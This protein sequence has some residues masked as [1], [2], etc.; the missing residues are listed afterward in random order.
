MQ[1]Q[2]YTLGS[3]G[4]H[5]YILINEKTDEA[6]LVDPADRPEVL[7]EK[8]TGQG[9]TLRG[10]LLTHGHGDHIMAV[11]GLREKY[12]APVLAHEAEAP[13][14]SD[15]GLNLSRSLFG[16]PLSLK[17]DRLLKDGELVKLAGLSLKVLFT[18]GHTP[19]GCCY[20]AEEEHVLL[21]GDTLFCASIGRTDFP[22]G[23]M[24]TL[25]AS[26]REKL[27]PLPDDTKVYPGHAEF[28]TL[29]QERAYNP[30]LQ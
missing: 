7:S 24:R 30:Y 11:P 13:L 12:Q 28:T 15:P 10:I 5:C 26:I 25:V 2:C 9:L 27:M 8:L 22:G 3:V 18:P 6:L 29:G 14:L 20:Y 16:T 17:A 1:I 23:S 19:G 21:S 4:T